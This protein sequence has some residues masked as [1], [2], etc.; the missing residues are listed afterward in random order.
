MSPEKLQSPT[1]ESAIPLTFPVSSFGR[2][3]QLYSLGAAWS[4][5]DCAYELGYMYTQGTG[6]PRDPA[7][8]AKYLSIVAQVRRN[9]KTFDT[10]NIICWCI[11]PCIGGIPASCGG[12]SISHFPPGLKNKLGQPYLFHHYLVPFI[13]TCAS[14]LSLSFRWACCKTGRALGKTAKAGVRQLYPGGHPDCFCF[15]RTGEGGA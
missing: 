13:T 4:H 9:E 12:F 10:K 14:N 8:A 2:A 1:D 7:H 11:C 3:A 6:V 15:V 5:V